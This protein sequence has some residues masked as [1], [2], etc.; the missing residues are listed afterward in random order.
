MASIKTVLGI[1]DNM[2][3][4]LKHITS[5]MGILINT[6][7]NMER[8][9]GNSI[10]TAAL[11]EARNHIAQ[12]AAAF[13]Q[14]EQEINQ[15][16]QAQNR[17]NQNVRN[18]T[19]SVDGLMNKLKGVLATVGGIAGIKM[20]LN[21]AKENMGLADIQRNAEN[22]LQAV[23]ANMGVLEVQVDNGQAIS[24][25]DAI[26]AKAQEIQ[27]QGIYGDEAMIAG[28][29]EFA[30]YFDDAKAIMSMMDTLS[31]YAMGM[32]GGGAIDS[33]A[34]V[35]YATNLGKIMS[36]SYDAMTK[37]GFEFTDAQ[38]AIIEGT[39][40]QQQ[41]VDTLGAEYLNCSDDMQAA[42]T[43]N[44]VIAES[45]DGLYATMSNTPEGTIIQFNNK[46]GDLRETLGN[47]I[48]PYVL[49][50][51]GAFSENFPQ[52]EQVLIAFTDL[53]GGIM[54]F[55]GYIAEGALSVAGAIGDNWSWI[56]P[57]VWGL[58]AALGAYLAIMLIVN[59]INGIVAITEGVKAAALKLSTGATFTATAAQY[60]LNAALMA[61]PITRIVI[62]VLALTVALIAVVRAMNL[63]GSKSTSVLGTIC[64][65]VNVVIQF[66]V[67]LG[68][69]VANIALGIWNALGACC[70]NM[71]IAFHNIIAN[72]Q[73]WFYGL[74]ADVLTVV[75][76]IAGALNKLPFVSFDY[77]G[78]AD[79]AD[80]YAAK[81]AEAYGNV[82]E[83]QN[84]A[85]AF[86][87]GFSTFDAFSDG[88]AQNAFDAGASFGDGITD[89]FSKLFD[90]SE[91]EM[92]QYNF[93]NKLNEIYQNTGDTAANTAEIS[94]SLDI[95]QEDLK[96]LM[97]IAE[98]EAINRFTTAEIKVEQHNENHI[99]K[100]VDV[101]GIM[102]A[103]AADFAE[104]LEIS[105]EGVTV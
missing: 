65:L 77:S 5:A 24:A 25:F 67:N 3:R 88:W 82:E 50:F 30:T 32:T 54:T 100:D 36:G 57:I 46:L 33:T 27:G 18:T 61:S 73:G 105:P 96:Y 41:V 89:Q 44:S 31:N 64:G 23:L 91:L 90:T 28:A 47:Q 75:A 39:A 52:V 99:D 53:L 8:I 12:A 80:E 42:A 79:K 94:D 63:F 86:K 29:A 1:Q 93:E 40:T 101:D 51:Y 9:S 56:E 74:L 70:A 16:S 62:G 11:A 7:E 48:Y 71:G 43:I 66:F 49:K 78:I 68:K 98:R 81:S 20:G 34:M 72:I 55:L 58:V 103:W 84:I 21:W 13:D 102:D 60:G 85:E 76:K 45:W 26:A 4:P 6:M 19:N 15:A 37:K 97:D 14:V 104:K 38:K 95:T 92:D 17:F 2:T 87:K 83:Y 35:D 69:T 59:T 10:D 22:Q